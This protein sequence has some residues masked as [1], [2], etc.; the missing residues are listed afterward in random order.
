MKR[1]S[2]SVEGA[3]LVVRSTIALSRVRDVRPLPSRASGVQPNVPSF[4]SSR[5]GEGYVGNM[6]NAS[7]APSP[8]FSIAPIVLPAP[9]R[10]VDLELRVS[11]PVTGTKLPILLLSHRHGPSNHLSSLNGYAP[12]ANYYAANGFVVVQPTHL[13]SKMLPFREGHRDSPLHWRTRAE[14]MTRILD[15]LDT[16][17]SA[18]A[19]IAS[20][21]DQSKVAVVGHSMG[22]HTA[23]L[24][25]GARSKDPRDGTEV[26][27][28][29]PR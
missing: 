29:E 24:I 7:S 21:T 28:V 2:E 19:E 27:S 5:T 3:E 12:L 16:I 6:T 17:E 26:N 14:D 18:V 10:A 25:L 1:D 8:V 15:H 9:G 11:A 4:Q 20:R 22:G 23:S 13:D